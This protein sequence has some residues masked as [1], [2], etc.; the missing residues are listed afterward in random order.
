MRKYN[1]FINEN[2]IHLQQEI[3]YFQ[4]LNQLYLKDKL[5]LLKK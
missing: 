2:I 1:I 4:L 3:H 5:Q